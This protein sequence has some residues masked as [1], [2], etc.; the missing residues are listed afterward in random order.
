MKIRTASVNVRL[1]SFVYAL[2]DE[3]GG[4]ISL[5]F[6]HRKIVHEKINKIFSIARP[7]PVYRY[8]NIFLR[9]FSKFLSTIKMKFPLCTVVSLQRR[10]AHTRTGTL[11]I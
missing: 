8:F 9:S 4:R 1:L 11:F 2:V 6:Y 5:I 3:N 7:S 10:L